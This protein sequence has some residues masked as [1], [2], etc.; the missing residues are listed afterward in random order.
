MPPSTAYPRYACQMLVDV[1]SSPYP[2]MPQTMPPMI[3]AH[4]T[5]RIPLLRSS[6]ANGWTNDS[7]T[8][9]KENAQKVWARLQW[10]A[11]WSEPATVPQVYSS[12]P[13]SIMA[14]QAAVIGTHRPQPRMSLGVSPTR[15][16]RP[17]VLVMFSK[18]TVLDVALI[19]RHRL[20]F[21]RDGD[22]SLYRRG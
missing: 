11:A 4:R 7:K 6:P 19:C 9:K 5:F 14:T 17:V 2:T 10:C 12:R 16:T 1:A 8:T 20:P 3:T 15:K 22:D 21:M 18:P 13:D